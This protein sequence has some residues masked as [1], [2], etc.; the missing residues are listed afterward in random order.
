[1]WIETSLSHVCILCDVVS[2]LDSEGGPSVF[3][4]MQSAS[5]NAAVWALDLDFCSL[6]H[7]QRLRCSKYFL[8]W[9]VWLAFVVCKLLFAHPFPTMAT[10]SKVSTFLKNA[11]RWSGQAH[12]A[13]WFNFIVN[14][15]STLRFAN[16][17]AAGGSVFSNCW[18]SVHPA[19][20]RIWCLRCCTLVQIKPEVKT[21]ICHPKFDKFVM[22]WSDF[23][24]WW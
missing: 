5:Y 4:K 6:F 20:Q 11:S 3:T 17:Q 21:A 10:H 22:Q 12:H 15:T 18:F 14:W 23:V 1:M 24:A 9:I 8:R 16:A 7:V 19:T 13:F 2:R